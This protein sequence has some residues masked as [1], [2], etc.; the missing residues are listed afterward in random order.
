MFEPY[1]GITEDISFQW[2]E[3]SYGLQYKE[4]AKLTSNWLLKQ[5]RG[6]S[7]KRN[8]LS[9]FFRS[10]I[11]PYKLPSNPLVFFDRKT[12]VPDFFEETIRPSIKSC[13]AISQRQAVT[14]N[15][16][17]KEF[18]DYCLSELVG[19]EDD[20]GHIVIPQRYRNPIKLKNRSGMVV[21]ETVY[22]PLPYKYILEL[23][24]ILC[25]PNAENFS[26]WKWAHAAGDCK[27]KTKGDGDWFEVEIDEIDLT[28]PNCV[29]RKRTIPKGRSYDG[30]KLHKDKIVYEMWCPVNA[31]AL[32]IKLELPLRTAQVRWLDSG[33]ADY[34][35]H[36]SGK[37]EI[38]DGPLAPAT[39]NE[40]RKYQIGRGVFR[41]HTDLESET[42]VLFVNSNK[43]ADVN[44]HGLSKGYV[45]PWQHERV[46]KWLEVLRNWQEKYNPIHS[47]TSWLSLKRKHTGDLKSKQQ[48]MEMGET[49]FLF[50]N[51]AVLSNDEHHF[52]ITERSMFRLWYGLLHQ[53][54]KNCSARNETLSN[55]KPLEF[56]KSHESK[57]SHPTNY[58][59]TNFPL[60]SLRVSLI[61][62]FALEGGVPIP[63][64][65]KLVA[66]HS[67]IVMTLYYTKIGQAYMQQVM[68]E[69]EKKISVQSQIQFKQFLVN[70]E[71]QD[72][73]EITAVN[74]VAALDALN[75]KAEL[76]WQIMDKGI[77]PIAFQG[78]DNGGEQYVK[79]GNAPI[80]Y[81][82]VV[83]DFQGNTKNCVRCRW[84]ITGPA[85]LP[86][87]IAHFNNLSYETSNA[88]ERY[89][90]IENNLEN[91]R[92]ENFA[93]E[94]KDQPFLKQQE[95][96]QAELEY[97]REA[98]KVDSIMNDMHA[99][100]QLI[101]RSIDICKNSEN[102]GVKLL[103]LEWQTI[104]D[105]RLDEKSLLM[106][107]ETVCRNAEIFP[108][109]DATKASLRR[110]QAI[111]LMLSAN[112]KSPVLLCLSE[113]EQLE[114]GNQIMMLIEGRV[115]SFEGAI[116]FVESMG[117][118]STLG[119]TDQIEQLTSQP[120]R[121]S[122][123]IS[124]K[125]RPYL[126]KMHEKS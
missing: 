119:I 92:L 65:S 62:S 85:F 34:W 52:P 89:I 111:D 3:S 109:Y 117:K 68:T 43:T 8:S 121:N 16:Y 61:T 2:L 35:R 125:L 106:Q 24:E 73:Q 31:V 104:P 108:S 45:I 93:S 5:E 51:R 44:K 123:D 86:G 39:K 88:G 67:R 47:P 25:P 113:A 120:Q 4:W 18:L 75:K 84:F 14:Y 46:L 58:W 101:K 126:G 100:Y 94:E 98:T 79:L 63:I 115:G 124:N 95:L 26:D 54:E 76:S 70:A 48:L 80:S 114:I 49:C 116:N 71:Y 81:A 22:T 19:V 110:G 103:S 77:C 32:L 53:L 33:E 10:F 102:E 105:L 90:A 23:R 57:V 40:I 12:V 97:E 72:L 74:H 50:R 9:R 17:I 55:G 21:T 82:P 96:I 91:L 83:R 122:L 27:V 6:L 78:C 118:L 69:A 37:W 11:I 59:T 15:N 99:T 1:G 28:D 42:T 64:L 66:G 107:L 41:K 30:L 60:H 56:V 87:L 38:N 112:G 36:I 13:E 20:Y 7:S 29:W